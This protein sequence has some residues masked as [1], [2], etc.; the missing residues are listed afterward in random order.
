MKGRITGED[1]LKLSDCMDEKMMDNIT[2][3]LLQDWPNVSILANISQLLK[4]KT[5]LLHSVIHIHKS[6]SRRFSPN[7]Q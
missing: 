3:Q 5:C 2:P 7:E 1:S 6:P 4:T